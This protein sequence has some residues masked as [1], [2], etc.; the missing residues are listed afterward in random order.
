MFLGFYRIW[1]GDKYLFVDCIRGDFIS[2][3]VIYSDKIEVVFFYKDVF[4]RLCLGF[5]CIREVVGIKLE[6]KGKV[7]LLMDI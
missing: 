2:Y 6:N 7:Y 5:A 4:R 1:V 3:F